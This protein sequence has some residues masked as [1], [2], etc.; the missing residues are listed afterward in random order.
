MKRRHPEVDVFNRA[1]L[2]ALD[3]SMRL[4]AAKEDDPEEA[5][6]RMQASGAYGLP[7]IWYDIPL[8][9]KGNR[10]ATNGH[11]GDVQWPPFAESLAQVRLNMHEVKC[12]EV[13]GGI[14]DQEQDVTAAGLRASLYSGACEGGKGGVA[15]YVLKLTSGVEVLAQGHEVHGHARRLEA[16]AVFL[17]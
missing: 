3:A 12:S 8:Y 1:C 17:V 2:R 15:A 10:F 14:R 16:V 11:E 13:W 6:K 9:Y 7:A 4:R 5:L